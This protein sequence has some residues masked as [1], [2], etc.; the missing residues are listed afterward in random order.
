MTVSELIDFLMEA[1]A[2][3]NGNLPLCYWVPDK[4]EYYE[5]DAD[6]FKVTTISMYDNNSEKIFSLNG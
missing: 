1:E 6:E 2:D 5:V 3:G 4:D